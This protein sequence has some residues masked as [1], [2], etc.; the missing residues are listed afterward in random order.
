[1]NAAE[2]TLQIGDVLIDRIV[3][4]E[5]FNIPAGT[6][7]P[8]LNISA[9][10]QERHWLEPRFVQGDDVCLSV[11]SLLIR[12]SDL[13]I[14]IDTCVGEHK[15]RPKNPHWHNRKASAYLENLARFGL[16]A[17]DIDHVFCTHLHGDHVGWNTRLQ[18]GRWVPTF[19]NA[20]YLMGRTELAH[21]ETLIAS[22]NAEVNHGS[23]QDSVLPVIE[24]KQGVLVDADH[25]LFNGCLVHPLPGHTPGQVGLK[26]KRSD[27]SALVT[28]D[29]IHHPIQLV[30]PDLSTAFC[31]DRDLARVTRKAFLED[32]AS[33]DTWLVPM[34]F[35]GTTGVRIH[36][37]RNGFRMADAG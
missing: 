9:F 21:W 31:T 28:G 22:G 11:H 13:C 4:I 7:F 29:A 36:K 14:L 24:A 30:F 33:E 16:R 17:D 10:E 3:D 12:T 25:E 1:M 26:L 27:A 6:L 5:R 34:H 37:S 35:R 18:D 20:K 23:Y 2:E 8:D 15:H 32:C 19:P